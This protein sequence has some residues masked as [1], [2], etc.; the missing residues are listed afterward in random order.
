MIIYYKITIGGFMSIR[1]SETFCLNIESVVKVIGKDTKQAVVYG[2][3]HCK[4]T[5]V[6]LAIDQKPDSPLLKVFDSV[7]GNDVD[8]SIIPREYLTTLEGKEIY[9]IRSDA[10]D[11]RLP[12][13]K[14]C[15]RRCKAGLVNL[16]FENY[17]RIKQGL[18]P[19]PLLFVIDITNNRCPLTSENICSKTK[20]KGVTQTF[21]ISMN[22]V[23]THEELRRAYKLCN[24]KDLGKEIN[25]VARQTFKFIKVFQNGAENEFGIVEIAA[26]WDKPDWATLWERRMI[27]SAHSIDPQKHCWRMQLKSLATNFKMLTL[28]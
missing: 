13:P 3:Q 7:I 11:P 5:Q 22:S 12:V 2:F 8:R 17:K 18:K 23:V 1:L 9:Q 28:Q 6:H 25:Q 20:T 27:E 24:E 19:I 26:P 21:S 16:V 14:Q 15:A 4:Y 10:G